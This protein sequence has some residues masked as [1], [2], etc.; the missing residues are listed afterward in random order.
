ME[1]DDEPG[2]YKLDSV[3]FVFTKEGAHA[4][5]EDLSCDGCKFFSQDTYAT[6]RKAKEDM[7]EGK[8]GS[9]ITSLTCKIKKAYQIP[10]V[11]KFNDHIKR[12]C[13]EP[14]NDCDEPPLCSKFDHM[15]S[16]FE[17]FKFDHAISIY[18]D[19]FE[20]VY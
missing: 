4:F 10:I 2:V 12:S 13:W 16:K 9:D 11:L 14:T 7:E 20:Y 8:P 3:R 1:D 19:S 18:R 17:Y 5:L 15:T 6:I